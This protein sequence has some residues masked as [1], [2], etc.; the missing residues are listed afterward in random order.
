MVW[1]ESSGEREI[2][3]NGILWEIATLRVHRANQYIY[4]IYPRVTYTTTPSSRLYALMI[5]SPPCLYGL[6]FRQPMDSF[7]TMVCIKLQLPG[8]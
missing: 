4:C 2:I 6:V 5:Y 1:I 8:K 7:S 3:V